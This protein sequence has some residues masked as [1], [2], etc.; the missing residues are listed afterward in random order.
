MTVIENSGVLEGIQETA[1]K[2]REPQFLG[3]SN[4]QDCPVH[5]PPR[6]LH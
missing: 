2:H 4:S 3:L 1:F 6:V 5:L